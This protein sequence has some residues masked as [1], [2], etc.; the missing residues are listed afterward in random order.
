[1]SCTAAE[2]E[3]DLHGRSHAR[4]EFATGAF[5]IAIVLASASIITGMVALLWSAGGLGAIG[6][7]FLFI[8]LIT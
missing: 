3:R 8:G 1:M 5:Q 7:V 4:Y 2:K 6:L